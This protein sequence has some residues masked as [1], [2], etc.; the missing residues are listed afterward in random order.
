MDV[1]LTLK[2]LGLG[3]SITFALSLTQTSVRWYTVSIG[4]ERSGDPTPVT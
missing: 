4:G 2:F 1:S 3:Q